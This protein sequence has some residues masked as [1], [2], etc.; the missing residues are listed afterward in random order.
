M[1]IFADIQFKFIGKNLNQQMFNLSDYTY[2]LPE[3][4]I[5]QVPQEKRDHSRLM[6]VDRESG[7]WQHNW[8]HQISD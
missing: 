1:F 8:F 3:Q 7:G 2:D 4:L 5:A 6:V